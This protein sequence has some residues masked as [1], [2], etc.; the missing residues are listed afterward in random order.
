MNHEKKW[1]VL[2][3]LSIFS[4]VGAFLTWSETTKSLP[5]ELA[6]YKSWTDWIW[7]SI[8]IFTIYYSRKHKEN[9]LSKKNIIV[10]IIATGVLFFGGL[11]AFIPN[12]RNNYKEIFEYENILQIKLP[13]TGILIYE[14]SSDINDNINNLTDMTAYYNKKIDIKDLDRQIKKSKVWINKKDLDNDLNKQLPIAIKINNFDNLYIL[15]YNKETKQYN[16]KIKDYVKQ[17]IILSVY[18]K[19]TRSINIFE[20]NYAVNKS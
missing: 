8:P 14:Q 11:F 6:F 9:R 3:Y 20:Y 17:D 1:N 15:F 7:M 12:E 5:Q 16:T 2:F 19:K 4:V 13:K 18:C 10:G